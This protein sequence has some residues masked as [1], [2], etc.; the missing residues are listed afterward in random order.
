MRGIG[1]VALYRDIPSGRLINFWINEH[2]GKR[3]HAHSHD[4]CIRARVHDRL[5]V[6]RV[7]FIEAF[8]KNINW[9]RSC[10][11]ETLAP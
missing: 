10:G 2:D 11:V 8:F 5:R 3:G 7:H 9:G 6:K 1:W 4:G